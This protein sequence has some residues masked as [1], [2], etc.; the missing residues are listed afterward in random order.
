[1]PL[2]YLLFAL[3][4]VAPAAPR[5]LNLPRPV[6]VRRAAD[7]ALPV[8]LE[9]REGERVWSWTFTASF[10]GSKFAEATAGN[11]ASCSPK[12]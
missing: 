2:F 5:A 4:S 11:R 12:I 8:L 10:R 6:E 7:P 3:V 1:M 9:L